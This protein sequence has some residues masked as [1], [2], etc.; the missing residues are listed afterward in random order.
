MSIAAIMS[1]M[2]RTANWPEDYRDLMAARSE[3]QAARERKRAKIAERPL[4]EHREPESCAG[5]KASGNPDAKMFWQENRD[6]CI[7]QAAAARR[8]SGGSR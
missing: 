2:T 3:T 8:G 1:E 6:L 7:A 5:I 4:P